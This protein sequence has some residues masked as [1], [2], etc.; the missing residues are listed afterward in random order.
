MSS[1]DIK[2]KQYNSGK[3]KSPCRL[4]KLQAILSTN[5]YNPQ[6]VRPFALLWHEVPW[7]LSDRVSSYKAE[8]IVQPETYNKQ[9]EK[10]QENILRDA[11]YKEH[12]RRK[13][14]K[15]TSSA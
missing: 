9:F 6:G 14:I 15:C 5:K 2:C 8:K 4:H 12:I 10:S 7:S 1:R 3:I 13:V 11:L